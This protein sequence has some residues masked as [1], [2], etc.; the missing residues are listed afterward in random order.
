MSA[1]IIDH[2]HVY[3][4][5]SG[6]GYALTNNAQVGDV[7][8]LFCGRGGTT[9]HDTAVLSGALASAGFVEQTSAYAAVTIA[10]SGVITCLIA[11]VTTAGIPTIAVTVGASSDLGWDAWV[12]RGLTGSLNVGGSVTD[13]TSTPLTISLSPSAA[14]SLFTYYLDESSD[15]FTSWNGSISLQQEDTGHTDASGYQLGVVAGSYTPG[16]NV[17]GATST[18]ISAVYMTEA[19]SGNVTVGLSGNAGTFAS[20]S[21]GTSDQP[22]LVGSAA[23]FAFGAPVIVEYSALTGQAATFAVGSE[24]INDSIGLTGQAGTFSVGSLTPSGGGGVTVP[25]TGY[26]ASFAVG[27]MAITVNPALLGSAA[28]FAVGA[29]SSVNTRTAIGQSATFAIGNMIPGTGASVTVILTGS[30]AHFSIGVFSPQVIT[31]QNL[32]KLVTFDY[33]LH[34]IKDY[35]YP[36]HVLTLSDYSI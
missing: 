13:S 31:Y 15:T 36:L 7:I 32:A 33:P 22:A 26:A 20:G 1:A 5:T 6:S 2:R 25:L 29:T 34:S 23:T 11:V 9:G 16:A 17:V 4:A 8:I 18:L 19:V 14:S 35:N 21:L 10:V 3:P 12:V 28:T 30:S 24:A 27:A